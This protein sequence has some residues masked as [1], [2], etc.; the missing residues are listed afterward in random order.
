M[1]DLEYPKSDPKI[2]FHI[3]ETTVK[4]IHTCCSHSCYSSN[5]L[6]D[7]LDFLYHILDSLCLPQGYHLE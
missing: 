7:R 6:P 1:E 5:S 4:P 2:A 3:N